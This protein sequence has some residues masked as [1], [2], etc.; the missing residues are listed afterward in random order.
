MMPHEPVR[1]LMRRT[2]RNLEF[3]ESHR[4]DTGPFEV[5]QLINSFL[6]AM[7]HPWETLKDE[8]DSI[9]ITDGMP[10]GWPEIRRGQASDECPASLGD[11][12]RLL[13][14]GIAHG[15]IQFLPD[16]TRQISALHIEN[17]NQQGRRTWGCILTP[18]EM[19]LFLQQFVRIVE[20]L[21]NRSAHNPSKIA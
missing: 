12:I 2:M 15:N 5:T 13:R 16:A 20:E 11:L 8:L 21:D 14:N 1:D 18:K 19:K 3:I 6:G 10:K 17:K 7:A 9:L 4:S